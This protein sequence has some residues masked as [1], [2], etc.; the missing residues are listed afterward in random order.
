MNSFDKDS[1]EHISV[2]MDFCKL[3]INL[4]VFEYNNNNYDNI[5]G[6]LILDFIHKQNIYLNKGYIYEYNELKKYTV[7]NS[8]FDYNTLSDINK[9]VLMIKSILNILSRQIHNKTY[10]FHNKT[11]ILNLLG[12]LRMLK[13]QYKMNLGKHRKIFKYLYENI[14]NIFID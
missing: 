11:L 10:I 1:W 6:F 3:L 4:L 12:H 13:N 9:I 14:N 8:E 5:E 7:L 2:K